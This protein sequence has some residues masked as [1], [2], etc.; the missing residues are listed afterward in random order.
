MSIHKV[1]KYFLALQQVFNKLGTHVMPTS[2]WNMDE[3]GLQ[4][5]FKPPKIVAARGDKTRNSISLVY[6]YI[7]AKHWN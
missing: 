2:I 6:K 7:F 4:L 1:S 5:D 3:T